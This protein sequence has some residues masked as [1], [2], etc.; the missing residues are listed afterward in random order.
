[1]QRFPSE[2]PVPLATAG[3]WQPLAGLQASAVQ[4]FPSSQS[5]GSPDR[6][7]SNASQASTPLQAFPSE[8]AAA[9]GKCRQASVGSSHTSVVQPTASSQVTGG[10]AWQPL[11]GLQISA[12]SQKAPSLHTALTAA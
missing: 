12:P 2:Q 4:G 1:L 7:P 5:G 9:L 10:P 8:Q 11:A 6:Q 3:C